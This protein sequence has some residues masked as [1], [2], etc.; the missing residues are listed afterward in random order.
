MG[1]MGIPDIDS[2]L[3]STHAAE[4]RQESLERR[5]IRDHNFPLV[6]DCLQ[7]TADFE[8]VEFLSPQS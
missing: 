2:S 7:I 3:H 5:S 8:I 4:I 1:P 6:L